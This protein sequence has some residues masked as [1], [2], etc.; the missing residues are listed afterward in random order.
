MVV[1][2]GG[3]PAAAPRPTGGS[4]YD[5]V[6]GEAGLRA[7]IDD[8]LDAVFGDPM[9][10]FLFRGK[11]HARIRAME[12]AF[13]AAHLGAG[14]SYDGRSMREAHARSPISSGHFARRREILRQTLARHAVPADVA[15]RWL[16]HV[17]GLRADVVGN[18]VEACG[19]PA[20][21]SGRASAE[22]EDA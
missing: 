11:N 20:P 9:I 2:L 13:A 21:V 3:T 17:D 1:R 15:E 6:G 14:L 18:F 19:D 10:G 7:I 8:F 4:D 16:A 5:R 12:Q 22:N